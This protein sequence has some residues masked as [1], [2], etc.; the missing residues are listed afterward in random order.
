MRKTFGKKY[1]NLEYFFNGVICEIFNKPNPDQDIKKEYTMSLLLLKSIS[2]YRETK[3][4]STKMLCITLQL[5]EIL[6][7]KIY[8]IKTRFIIGYQ[9]I[10][11]SKYLIKSANDSKGITFLYSQRSCR[12]WRKEN[13]FQKALHFRSPNNVASNLSKK[14]A[15]SGRSSSKIHLEIL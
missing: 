5:T 6:V 7:K 8:S 2:R 1:E 3:Q 14:L 4:V 10:N 11:I 9:A 12:P 13:E 15:G